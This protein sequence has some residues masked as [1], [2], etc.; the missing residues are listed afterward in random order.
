MKRI[1]IT[2]VP[3]PSNFPLEAQRVQCVNLELRRTDDSLTF[4]IS[5]LIESTMEA[6]DEAL[7]IGVRQ[8][9]ES[10]D[11]NKNRL[12]RD[13]DSLQI[14]YRFVDLTTPESQGKASLLELFQNLANAI[15]ERCCVY[16]D[17]TFGTKT[18]PLLLF[19]AL[20]YA[21]KVKNCD[22]LSLIYQEQRR[23]PITHKP[24]T[25]SIY[26]VT[27]LFYLS[28]IINTMGFSD[29]SVRDKDELLR[30]LLRL[31]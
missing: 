17:V 27:N 10:G 9:N 24:T 26:D 12:L 4:P 6:G 7:V 25:T 31:S 30:S 1:Y 5:R 19:A 13:L 21:E 18:Y 2:A 14:D 28:G 22:V 23:D 8:V 11:E 16:A 3:L 29:A 15:E 20:N